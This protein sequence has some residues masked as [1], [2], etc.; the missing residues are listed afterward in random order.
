MMKCVFLVLG[1]ELL[2]I[3]YINLGLKGLMTRN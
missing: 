2:N 1:P 3:I